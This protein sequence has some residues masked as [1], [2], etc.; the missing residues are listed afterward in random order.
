MKLVQDLAQRLRAEWERE[1][2]A[3]VLPRDRAVRLNRMLRS[4]LTAARL[5]RRLT[6]PTQTQGGK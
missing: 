1:R 3:R 6:P 2:L 4:R 5:A